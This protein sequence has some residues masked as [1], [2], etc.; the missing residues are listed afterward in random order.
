MD[1]GVSSS[2]D[3]E[4]PIGLGGGRKN[5]EAA[6]L[7]SFMND[8]EDDDS[9]RPRRRRERR[10]E[11][12]T[13]MSGISFVQQTQEPV[14]EA[15]SEAPSLTN[16]DFRSSMKE[17][18]PSSQPSCEPSFERVERPKWEQHT[19]GYGSRLLKKMGFKGRLGKDETGTAKPVEVSK[20]PDNLGLGFGESEKKMDVSFSVERQKKTKK[21]NRYDVSQLRTKRQERLELEEALVSLEELSEEEVLLSK[22]RRLCE[23]LEVAMNGEE[24][25]LRDAE[26]RIKLEL[27]RGRAL[28]R[29]VS[30][31]RR[32]AEASRR[33]FQRLHFADDLAKA[34]RSRYDVTNHRKTAMDVKQVADNLVRLYPQEAKLADVCSYDYFKIPEFLTEL[35]EISEEK[36]EVII[37]DIVDAWRIVFPEDDFNGLC[38]RIFDK[39]EDLRQVLTN[40]EIFKSNEALTLCETLRAVGAQAPLFSTVLGPRLCR[41]L[42]ED[43]T[44]AFSRKAAAWVQKVFPPSESEHSDLANAGLRHLLKLLK[45]AIHSPFDK[46]TLLLG[47]AK[48]AKAWRDCI[49]AT[50]WKSFLTQQLP[51]LL[52]RASDPR[53]LRALGTGL[54]LPDGVVAALLEGEL[55]PRAAEALRSVLVEQRPLDAALFYIDWR[56]ALMNDDE[57]NKKIPSFGPLALEAALSSLKRCLDLVEVSLTLESAAFSAFQTNFT[58][59]TSYEEA[60]RRQKRRKVDE[61]KKE[62]VKKS[63]P[64]QAAV[65]AQG[66]VLFHDVVGRFAEEH[67]LVF[68]PKHRAHDGKQ[69]FAFGSAT[70]YIDKNVTF[71][72]DAKSRLWT[73]MA[74]ENLLTLAAA[75]PAPNKK[76]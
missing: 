9:G 42:K 55:A 76:R 4:A 21:K 72:Y 73:P 43:A 39:R 44:P 33:R 41:L 15:V 40:P 24:S 63:S 65:N 49:D 52:A 45:A 60:L 35:L 34:C 19:T 61:E 3:D 59:S 27:E 26:K 25:G 54:G 31:S 69:L 37:V 74:L 57:D 1:Y 64:W 51:P 2:D 20:R 68:L 67:D 70:I 56:N 29:E 12:A 8:S 22:A 6:M 47:C 58:E 23:A 28:K 53:V 46:N 10:E 38:R 75:T 48:A 13:N 66:A 32:N 14:Q 16:A 30:E 7:G 18:K 71:V 62:D 50:L 36:L 5:K 17:A 11:E